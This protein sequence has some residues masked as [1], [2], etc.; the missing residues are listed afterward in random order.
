MNNQN[1]PDREII[2]FMQSNSQFT[3]ATC[4]D[5]QPYCAICYY[6]YSENLNAIIF[7]S[8]SGSRHINEA[9]GN[10]RVAAAIA[11]N[12][13]KLTDSKGVQL[14]GDFVEP[15]AEQVLEAKRCYYSKFPFALAI[16]GNIWLIKLTKIKYTD[17]R[18]GSLN[19]I[20]WEL[21]AIK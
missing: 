10:P 16:P 2:K 4:E 7:K 8:N 5:Q 9:Q 1:S 20:N 21:K 12:K 14:E 6:A 15:N 11:S 3:I 18:L 17:N 19:K 13:N